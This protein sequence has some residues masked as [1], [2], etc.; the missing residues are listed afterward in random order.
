MPT[1]GEMAAIF[2]LTM[3]TSADGTGIKRFQTFV[4]RFECFYSPLSNWRRV[5]NKRRE[6]RR[7]ISKISVGSRNTSN[8]RRVGKI[9]TLVGILD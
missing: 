1:A 3:S 4:E 5:S 7:F 8:N 9:H 6:C 2:Y